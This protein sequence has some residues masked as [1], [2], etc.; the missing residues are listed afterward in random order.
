MVVATFQKERKK[1]S[2]SSHSSRATLRNI[3]NPEPFFFLYE[4]DGENLD[5]RA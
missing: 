3:L 5:G 4:R 1:C 2:L